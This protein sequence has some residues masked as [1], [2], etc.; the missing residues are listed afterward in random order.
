LAG[1]LVGRGGL[2]VTDVGVSSSFQTATVID[3]GERRNAVGTARSVADKTPFTSTVVHVF[4]LD[5]G[6][7]ARCDS[8]FEYAEIVN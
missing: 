3:D 6:L 2:V 8:Y 7:I 5:D 4:E 1:A